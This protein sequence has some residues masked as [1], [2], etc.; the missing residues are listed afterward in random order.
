MSSRNARLS[1]AERHL[2]PRLAEILAQ[3]ARRL[4]SGES[5]K[6]A[7]I[8]ARE[9]ILAAGFS[10]VEYLEL[11][12]D[13]DLAS[14]AKLDRP[15]RLLVAAWLGQTRL[16]GQCRGVVAA[17]CCRSSKPLL[18]G[19]RWTNCDADVGGGPQRVC[20]GG[21]FVTFRSRLRELTR[22]SFNSGLVSTPAGSHRKPLR[23]AA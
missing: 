18:D 11:R 23:S 10:K 14:I 4:S 5:L 13:S 9:A 15:A 1:A 16:I 17:T 21:L 3:T 6:R 19:F 20:L 2:A 12:A 7:L 8:D 22:C